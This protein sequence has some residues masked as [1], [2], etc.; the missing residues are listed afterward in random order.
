MTRDKPRIDF[1]THYVIMTHDPQPSQTI[2]S[3]YFCQP[4]VFNRIDSVIKK[5]KSLQQQKK[6]DVNL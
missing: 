5:I 4:Q 2:D 1:R 3:Y 6:A